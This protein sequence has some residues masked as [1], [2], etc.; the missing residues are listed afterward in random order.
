MLATVACLKGHKW[1]SMMIKVR[2]TSRSPYQETRTAD[3]DSARVLWKL[4]SRLL[5]GT[6]FVCP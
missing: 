3:L 1:K 4:A 6:S 2:S 5:P